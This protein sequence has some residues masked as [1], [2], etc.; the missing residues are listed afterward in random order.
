VLNRGETASLVLKWRNALKL[1]IDLSRALDGLFQRKIIHGNLTPANVL[2]GLDRE[3]RLND[4][5]Y[6][7]A[8]RGSQWYNKR[9]EAK[10]LAELPYMAPERLEEGAYY[11]SVADIYS[12]GALVY[13]R[14]T[15]RPPFLA[16]TPAAMIQAIREGNLVKPREIIRGCPEKFE[17]VILKMLAHN[18]EDRYATPAQ[19]LEEL[20]RLNASL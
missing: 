15:S 10:L 8:L 12:L 16:K 20:D 3:V 18:Q 9:L 1:G 19:V 4:L 2:I 14:L 7:E 13:A 6:E 5:M 11:D 17:A